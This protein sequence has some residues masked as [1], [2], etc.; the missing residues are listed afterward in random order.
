MAGPAHLAS[1]CTCPLDLRL[2]TASGSRRLGGHTGQLRRQIATTTAMLPLSRKIAFSCSFGNIF[3][4]GYSDVVLLL[5][6]GRNVLQRRCIQC[7]LKEVGPGERAEISHR[8]SRFREQTV[9][10][11]RSAVPR[12]VFERFAAARQHPNPDPATR[13]WRLSAS[14]PT[15][16]PNDNQI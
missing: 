9:L 12:S 7:L 10:A 1:G 6:M 2:C 11:W 14:E 15:S 3:A 8:V 16:S 4:G 13:A 5:Q